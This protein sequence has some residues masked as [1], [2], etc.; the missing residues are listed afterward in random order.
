MLVNCQNDC[1]LACCA[2]GHA[3]LQILDLNI[4]VLF[5]FTDKRYTGTVEVQ[6]MFAHEGSTQH[7]HC[8]IRTL[9]ARMLPL[10]VVDFIVLLRMIDT[11]IARLRLQSLLPEIKQQGDD[12]IDPATF[13]FF[14]MECCTTDSLKSHDVDEAA[15]AIATLLRNIRQNERSNR[16]K[17]LER[18]C[19]PDRPVTG[20]TPVQTRS[21]ISRVPA[22]AHHHIKRKKTQKLEQA[23]VDTNDTNETT[24]EVGVR[25]L[26]QSAGEMRDTCWEKFTRNLFLEDQMHKP[27]LFIILWLVIGTLAY[28]IVQGWTVGQSFYF[29]IQ[30]RWVR[31]NSF[32]FADCSWSHCMLQAGF[33]VGFGAFNEDFFFGRNQPECV[34]CSCVQL[35]APGDSFD[36]RD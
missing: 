19:P 17:R 5:D 20:T 25:A 1:L 12:G 3:T 22:T 26:L 8:T 35:M 18:N 10:Q 16:R 9:N 4:S 27:V 21:R 33:S 7:S 13:K 31:F 32:T 11:P 34:V 14:I 30:V 23:K 6:A 36:A 2:N 28:L 15:V 24:T 29:M